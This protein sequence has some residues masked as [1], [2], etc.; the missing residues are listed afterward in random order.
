VAKETQ[1]ILGMMNGIEGDQ[2]VALT[3]KAQRISKK[4]VL[5]GQIQFDHSQLIL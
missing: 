2:S 5:G 1:G 3:R 4:S